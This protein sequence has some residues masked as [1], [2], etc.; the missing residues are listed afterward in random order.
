M[1]LTSV[2]S[3]GL[4]A[5]ATACA[6]S[7]VLHLEELVAQLTIIQS[8]NRLNEKTLRGEVVSL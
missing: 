7:S 3:D 6:R 8:N 4:C 5:T 1:L 2:Y